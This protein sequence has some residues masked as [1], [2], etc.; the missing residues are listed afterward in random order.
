MRKRI[1]LLIAALMLALTM[2]FG[3]V[4]AFAAPIT[5]NGNQTATKTASGWQCINNGDNPTGSARHQGTGDKVGKSF[6]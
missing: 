4:A 2:A 5:C 3:S 1:S 6:P